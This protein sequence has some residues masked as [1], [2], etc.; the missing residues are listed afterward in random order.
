MSKKSQ[1]LADPG[2]AAEFRSNP[3]AAL[4][5]AAIGLIPDAAK[6]AP[7]AAPAAAAPAKPK[8]SAADRELLRVFGDGK[9]EVGGRG[10]APGTAATAPVKGRV[11]LQMQ[12]KGKGG[13]TVTRVLGLEEL[14]LAA[15]M[16]LASSLRQALGTGA[17]FDEGV[18]ELHGDLRTRA[19]DWFRKNHY[20]AD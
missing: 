12:R 9:V 17:H 3:F 8:L 2:K 13:K 1:K 14:D 4:K 19:A 7:A 20:R 10:G 16:E 5:P 15:Q 6:A 11:R 18:L